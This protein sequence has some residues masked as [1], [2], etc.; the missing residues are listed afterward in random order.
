MLERQFQAAVQGAGEH[1]GGRPVRGDLHHLL[2][3][4]GG[5]HR[6][7]EEGR[8]APHLAA[9]GGHRAHRVRPGRALRLRGALGQRQN[10]D[11]GRDQTFSK[12]RTHSLYLSP[13]Y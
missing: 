9:G 6:Q 4:H 1:H 10:D 13:R 12:V 3:L 5:R 7:E 11:G 2:Q 8:A